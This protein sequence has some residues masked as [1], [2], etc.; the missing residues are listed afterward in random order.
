MIPMAQYK[1]S[2]A[3]AE[4]TAT[5][6]RAALTRAGIPE[7]AARVHALVTGKERAKVEV[8]ALPISSAVK[9][10]NA[11]SLALPDDDTDGGPALPAEA[12]G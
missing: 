12:F 1:S 8:G 2:R 10:L 4:R 5:L 11:L 7:D 9:L 6:L 3:E